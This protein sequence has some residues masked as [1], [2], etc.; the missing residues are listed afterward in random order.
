VNVLITGL[1]GQLGAGVHET[2]DSHDVELIPLIR[3]MHG[4]DPTRWLSFRFPD[5]PDLVEN[6]LAGDITQPLWGLDERDLLALAPRVDVVVNLAAETNWAAREHILHKTNAL[7]AAQGLRLARALYELR[8]RCR[9]YCHVGSIYVAGGRTGWIEEQAFGPDGCRTPY[10]HT[11][12][13]GEQMLIHDAR[14]QPDVSLAIVRVGTLLGHSRTGATVSR[15]ALYML[16]DRASKITRGVIPTA[17]GGR[18][19]ALP[20]DVAGEYLLRTVRA[21]YERAQRQPAIYHLCAGESAPTLSSLLAAAHSLDAGESLGTLRPL[22]MPAASI[23]WLSQ[24]I[25]RFAD[26]NPAL[27]NALTGLRYLGLDR[28]FERSRLAMLLGGDLP[29]V[30]AD[31]LAQLVFGLD[32]RDA[33]PYRSQSV[34]ARFAG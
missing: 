6:A 21:A 18:I 27:L 12:W 34:L 23:L 14:A 26:T 8:G 3:R 29:R 31:L 25:G 5:S 9:L 30:S 13:L 33:Q 16:A 4:R 22:R 32:P 28:I 17:A 15:N 20:R 7:G 11:K 2:R 10:E 19:D 24:N 1:T